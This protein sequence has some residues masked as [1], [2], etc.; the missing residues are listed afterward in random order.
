MPETPIDAILD[1][2]NCIGVS[3]GRRGPQATDP[4]R[5]PSPL[6][7]PLRNDAALRGKGVRRTLRTSEGFFIALHPHRYAER[8]R[9]NDKRL[10]GLFGGDRGYEYR[11]GLKR[12]THIGSDGDDG[13]IGYNQLRRAVY[14]EE[15]KEHEGRGPMKNVDKQAGTEL[16]DTLIILSLQV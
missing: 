14:T 4:T 5:Q 13:L 7:V 10:E 6:K 1:V 15:T 3:S 8:E 11:T 16:G 9:H 12:V 2:H